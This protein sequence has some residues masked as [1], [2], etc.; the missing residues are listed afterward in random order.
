MSDHVVDRVAFRAGDIADDLSVRLPEGVSD[1]LVAK[2]D[3]RRYY[4]LLAMVLDQ[5]IDLTFE[6]AM[7][8]CKAVRD[9][10]ASRLFDL[11]PDVV[12]PV[13]LDR[14]QHDDVP[15]LAATVL[16]WSPVHRLAVLDAIERWVVLTEQGV[17][18]EEALVLAGLWV[19]TENSHEHAA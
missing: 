13:L 16:K 1:G 14:V 6:E 15:L 12:V 5:D 10:G 7:E 11:A 4:A 19:E 18:P 3:L 2:R 9:S 17:E 8:C